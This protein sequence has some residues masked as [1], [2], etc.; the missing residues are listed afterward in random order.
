MITN[1]VI[2]V[3]ILAVIAAVVLGGLALDPMGRFI[4]YGAGTLYGTGALLMRKVSQ[5]E[6]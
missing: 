1:Q 2:V 3:A 6:V 5:I 4:L